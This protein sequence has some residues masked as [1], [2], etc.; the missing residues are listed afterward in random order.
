MDFHIREY[1]PADFPAL[2]RLDQ[3]C[4]EPG[5]AYSRMELMHYLGRRR[6]FALVAEQTAC[7]PPRIDG[8]IVV[9]QDRRNLAHVITIDVA[10]EA[11]RG[12]LGS[13]LM[14]EAEQ[15]LAQQGCPAVYLETAVDNAA[16]I[17]FYKRRGYAVLSTIPRYYNGTIDALVMG[18]KL[19]AR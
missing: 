15:R 19:S 7:R 1:R 9:E 12:G 18:K 14:E 4:F 3:D 10:A 5:I 16:A 11:R 2:Y 17:A 13:A 8:F 6:S